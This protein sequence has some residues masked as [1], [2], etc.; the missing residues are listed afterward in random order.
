MENNNKT[1]VDKLNEAREYWWDKLSGITNE[2]TFPYDEFV[3]G[4][5]KK[6]NTST[7]LDEE[8]TQKLLAMSKN[9]DMALYVILTAGLEILMYKLIGFNDVSV[10][11]SAFDMGSE[12]SGGCILLRGSL[13]EDITFKE[14]LFNT[15]EMVTSAYKHQYYSPEKVINQIFQ[16]KQISLFRTMLFWKVLTIKNGSGTLLNLL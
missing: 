16:D 13:G 4:S 3:N 5:V 15:K 10:A 12:Q 8:L 6:S 9:N 2:T 1:L 14:L 7:V 11:S